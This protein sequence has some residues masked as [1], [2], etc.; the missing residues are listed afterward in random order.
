MKIV[1]KERNGVILKICEVDDNSEEVF[2]EVTNESYDVIIKSDDVVIEDCHAEEVGAV[3]TNENSD[4]TS[5]RMNV[6]T[7]S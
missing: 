1:L 4:K 6:A 5:C 2:C 7:I 3:S